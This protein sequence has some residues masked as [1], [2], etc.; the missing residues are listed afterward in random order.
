VL[1]EL[2]GWKSN[3]WVKI[4]SNHMGRNGIQVAHG[5]W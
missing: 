4:E 1:L 3:M 2:E 5:L